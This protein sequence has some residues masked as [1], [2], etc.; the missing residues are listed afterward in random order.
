ML[1][2]AP[3]QTIGLPPGLTRGPVRES[4]SS[5]V[6]RVAPGSRPGAAL[7][8]GKAADAGRLP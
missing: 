1:A 2:P 8:G 6:G 4:L 7:V 5:G 3:V